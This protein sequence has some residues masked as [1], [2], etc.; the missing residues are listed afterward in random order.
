MTQDQFQSIL[1]RFGKDIRLDVPFSELTT[2]GIGGP[3]KALIEVKAADQLM[4]IIKFCQDQEI[5][6]LVMGGG[7]NLLV[8][9]SGVESLVIKLVNQG[10]RKKENKLIV[11][12]GTALQTLVDYTIAKGL[13]GFSTMN[14]IPGTLGG[15]IYG[16]AGAYGDNIRN[17]LESVLCFDGERMVT[18]TKAE[19]DTGYRDSIF[20]RRK[21]LVILEAIFEGMPPTDTKILKQEADEVW[22]KR[23]KKYN[24]ILKT[25]GSFFKNIPES[26][27]APKQLEIVRAKIQQFEN[28]P[29]YIERFGT[30]QIVRFGKIPAGTLIDMLGGKGDRIGQIRIDDFHANTFINDGG[31]TAADFWRLA[32]KWHDRVKTEFGI[33]LEPEV[34]FVNLPPLNT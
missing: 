17:F 7:S 22:Q 11:Q 20:K 27:L 34:Q 29:E 26:E 23:Q 3:A 15:A 14:G 19:Y 13:D 4:E 16:S 28:T 30:S 1:A 5:P 8:S 25:P 9:D 24:P 2:V 6:F 32:K 10:I 31:G 12:S 21:D 33:E 18:L